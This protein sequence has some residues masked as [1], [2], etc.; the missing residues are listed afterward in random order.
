MRWH[1]EGKRDKPGIM[2]HPADGEAWKHF[3]EKYPEFAK[4][5]RN[6][7]FGLTTD[8]FMP[9]NSSAAP[10]SCWPV[11]IFPKNIKSFSK[12]FDHKYFSTYRAHIFFRGKT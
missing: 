10:Y 4:E 8:G 7:V 3:M 5:V 6:V 2:V 9:F 12:I 1:K 11:F